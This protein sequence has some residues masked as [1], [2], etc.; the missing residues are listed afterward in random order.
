MGVVRKAGRSL[1]LLEKGMRSVQ[2]GRHIAYVI[3]LTESRILKIIYLYPLS[4][5]LVS[6]FFIGGHLFLKIPAQGF[7]DFRESENE[8]RKKTSMRVRNID[9]M[10]LVCTLTRNQICNLGM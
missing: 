4:L 5:S 10:P 9:Q 1:D 8:E 6:L 3:F 2:S 7:I